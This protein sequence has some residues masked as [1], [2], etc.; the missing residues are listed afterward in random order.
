MTILSA[1]TVIRSSDKA[2]LSRVSTYE[3]RLQAQEGILDIYSL[4]SIH[5][6]TPTRQLKFAVEPEERYYHEYRDLCTLCRESFRFSL[7]AAG[8]ILMLGFALT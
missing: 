2:S 4:A 7:M 3:P 6:R 8:M 1:P 5:I